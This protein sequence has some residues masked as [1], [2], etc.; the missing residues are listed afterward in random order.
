[1]VVHQGRTA[2]RSQRVEACG[3]HGFSTTNVERRNP[4]AAPVINGMARIA[5]GPS[6]GANTIASITD[7]SRA[8]A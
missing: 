1:L 7:W 8:H 5:C 6:V 4:G 3:D 2:R